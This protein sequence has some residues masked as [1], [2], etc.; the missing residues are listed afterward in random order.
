MQHLLGS[1]EPVLRAALD[2]LRGTGA[3]GGCIE[4][5]GLYGLGS[6]PWDLIGGGLRQCMP[7]TKSVVGFNRI[8]S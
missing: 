6:G 1:V 4:E 3:E 5:T 2:R 8:Q 7:R